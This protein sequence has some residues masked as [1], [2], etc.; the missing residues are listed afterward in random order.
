MTPQCDARGRFCAPLRLSTRITTSVGHSRERFATAG[1]RRLRHRQRAASTRTLRDCA[2]GMVG[3]QFWS[4][5]VPGD[6]FRLAR[7]VQL[8][9]IDIA[10][11]VIAKYPQTCR[12]RSPRD[13]RRAAM[14]RGRIALAARHGRR[15]RHRELARRAA[16]LLRPGRALHDAHAQRHA[17]LGRRRHRQRAA[18]RAHAVRRGSRA[19]DEPPRHARRPLAR[20]AGHDER[21]ARRDRGAGDLLALRRRGRSRITRATCPTRSSRGCRRTAAW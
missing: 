21:R 11:R 9:Q 15:P 4:V 8:E 5:Y 1:R 18:R 3:G 7:A 6:G 19:R 12:G 17:R 14:A 13:G 2:R 20:V 10:R 16:R